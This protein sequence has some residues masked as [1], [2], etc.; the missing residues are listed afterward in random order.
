[1]ERKRLT[2][3][4]AGIAEIVT[5]RFVQ[6]SGFESNYVITKLGRR[7]SRVRALGLVV[8]KFVSEDGN[9]ATLTLDDGSETIRCKTFVNT[10]IF[11]GINPGDLVDVIGKVREYKDEIYVLP[12]TIKK[13]DANLETLRMLELKRQGDEQRKKIKIVLDLK[14]QTADLNELKAIAQKSGVSNEEAE[15]IL[16][17]QELIE[18]EME[19]KAEESTGVKEKLLKL[20]DEM[21]S[22]EGVDYMELLSK[23][24]LAENVVDSAIQELLESGTCFEPRAGKIKRI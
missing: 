19:K 11:D 21:D 3:K 6:R 15:A 8:D 18:V 1:M 23:S 24:G 14:N 2:A 13:A 17:A 22:G 20:I 4:K 12:E 7:L 5:G 9:Y 10:R 16:E